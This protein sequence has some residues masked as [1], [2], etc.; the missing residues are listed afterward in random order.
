M[1]ARAHSLLTAAGIILIILCAYV[2]KK[3]KHVLEKKKKPRPD[4]LSSFPNRQTGT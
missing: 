1:P 4:V 3:I 2:L